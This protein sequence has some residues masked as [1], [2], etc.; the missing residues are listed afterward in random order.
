MGNSNFIPNTFT[1]GTN[2][3]INFRKKIT[4]ALNANWT[5][6]QLTFANWTDNNTSESSSY[7]VLVITAGIKYNGSFYPVTFG[8]VSYTVLAAGSSVTSDAVA[9]I[10]ITAGS[11]VERCYRL[12]YP[13]LYKTGTGAFTV[14]QTVTGGTSGATGVIN[15]K[16]GST[17]TGSLILVTETGTFQNNET[18]TDPLGGSALVDLTTTQNQITGIGSQAGFNEGSKAGNDSTV[19]WSNSDPVVYPVYTANVNGSG[20]IT[21][22]SKTSGGS[23]YS[24]GPSLY[25][26]EEMADGTTQFKNIGY[27]N[28]SGGAVNSGTVTSGTC[29][30]G[31][32]WTNPTVKFGGGTGFGNTT[33]I[34]DFALMTAIPDRPVKSL[35]LIGDSIARGYTSDDGNGDIKHNFG[36]YERAIRNR[37]GVI[38]MSTSGG[39][40]AN[41]VQYGTT[42][43]KQYGLYMGK[44]THALITLATNDI[45]TGATKSS[46]EA[47][48]NTLATYIRTFGT[49]VAA[50]KILPRGAASN[51]T[52]ISQAAS[53]V[54]TV[55]NAFNVNDVVYFGNTDAGTAIGGMTQMRGLTGTV[56]AASPTQITVNIDS[57]AFSVYTS[58]GGV[59]SMTPA[60]QKTAVGFALGGVRDTYNTDIGN[61]TIVSDWNFVDAST[62]FQDGT[63][64]FAWLNLSPQLTT[65]FVHPSGRGLGYGGTDA[66]LKSYFNVLS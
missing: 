36:I 37:F 63:S 24:S 38:N 64:T 18:I 2:R 50:G 52:A 19:N 14:G 59:F 62:T 22:V 66:T 8:G 56:T 32:V 45:L 54:V 39:A 58:G 61:G 49:L 42:F 11:E 28:L 9:G 30:A 48:F 29:N 53:A 35:I 43:V 47:N 55:N 21:S 34:P 46:V 12:T 51:I 1:T 27:G 60:D 15:S 10:S 31:Y 13:L 5:S 33:A 26:Y 41:Q 20:V 44:A 57:S 7:P 16:T 40:L 4:A 17:A 23:G 65:D 6:P 25:A 3:F